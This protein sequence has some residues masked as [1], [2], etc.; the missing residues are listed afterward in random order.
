MHVV[1]RGDGLVTDEGLFETQFD[2]TWTDD[3]GVVHA[4][5]RVANYPWT[6]TTV[7]GGHLQD[8]YSRFNLLPVVVTCLECL[9]NPHGL[10]A[11]SSLEVRY[12]GNR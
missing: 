12:V 5:A 1:P 7:C 10:A 11:V 4:W 6:A 3:D 2:V 8:A 9:A